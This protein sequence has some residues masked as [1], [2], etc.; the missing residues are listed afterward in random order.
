MGRSG[1]LALTFES[2][3][4]V[5]SSAEATGG[6]ELFSPLAHTPFSL[7]SLLR[8]VQRGRKEGPV[9]SR[10][11][12]VRYDLILGCT[13][14]STSNFKL[15]AGGSGKARRA[16]IQAHIQA[17]LIR[18]RSAS[19]VH[20]CARWPRAATRPAKLREERRLVLTKC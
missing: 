12:G 13:I 1:E 18:M 11:P 16:H 15:G 2:S 3:E 8:L 14:T 4:R 20:A 7:R 5:A 9:A 6:G 17:H 19:G 10:P